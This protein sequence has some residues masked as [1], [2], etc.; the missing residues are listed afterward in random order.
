MGRNR[1]IQLPGQGL[2]I[3]GMGMSRDNDDFWVRPLPPGHTAPPNR[4][5]SVRRLDLPVSRSGLPDDL[6]PILLDDVGEISM[7]LWAVL[8]A[9]QVTF[10]ADR[11]EMAGL[12][13]SCLFS[14][15][16]AEEAGDVAPWLV[17]LEAD[18]ALLH[19][20][21]TTD[22]PDAR[23]FG[24]R[25]AGIFLRSP[26]PLDGLRRHFRR[27]TRQRDRSGKWFYVR[28]YDP[29]VLPAYLASMSAEKQGIFFGPVR[30]FV[31]VDRNQAV[32]LDLP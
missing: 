26:A 19:E 14:G 10:L 12:E 16:T 18:S 23:T 15:Q 11:L 6:R 4:A 1:A 31:A 32:I 2:S 24:A 29:G 5:L 30:R 7:P 22:S 28:F 8:D 20:A 27:F 17:R 13:Y 3:R 9:A 21:F 25:P